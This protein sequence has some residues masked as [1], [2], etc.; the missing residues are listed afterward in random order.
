MDLNDPKESTFKDVILTEVRD[1]DA[2]STLDVPSNTRENDSLKDDTTANNCNDN[3]RNDGVNKVSVTPVSNKDVDDKKMIDTVVNEESVAASVDDEENIIVHI[4]EENTLNVGKEEGIIS[5]AANNPVSMGV[6]KKC[7]PSKQNAV[8]VDLHL[9]ANHTIYRSGNV[10]DKVTSDNE[11]DP[12]SSLSSS[13]SND[14]DEPTKPNVTEKCPDEKKIIE[15]PKVKGELGIEDLP[16]IEELK[17]TA[18]DKVQL[19]CVGLISTIID[20]LVVV[21]SLE[22]ESSPLNDD[23]IL[24]LKDRTSLGQ[25]FEIFGPVRN[26]MYSVRFNTTQDIQEKGLKVGT[27][28]YYAPKE[29]KYTNYVFVQDLMKQKGSD[30]SWEHDLEPPDKFLDYSD[31]EKERLM[32]K[33]K[34]KSRDDNSESDDSNKEG[35]NQAHRKKNS[36]NPFYLKNDSPVTQKNSK[37]YKKKSE[38]F[39]HQGHRNDQGSKPQQINNWHSNAYTSWPPKEPRPQSF[40]ASNNRFP[41]TYGNRP[42]NPPNNW[43]TNPPNQWPSNPANSWGQTGTNNWP[44]TNGPNKWPRTPNSWSQGT[45]NSWSQGTP[46]SWSQSTPNN[47]SQNTPNNWSLNAPNNWSQNNPNTSFQNTPNSS[48]QMTPNNW[49]A[50][51]SWTQ[52]NPNSWS[53]NTPNISAQNIPHG[54]SQINPNTWSSNWP[55]NWSSNPNSLPPNPFSVPPPNILNSSS[56]NSMSQPSAALPNNPPPNAPSW[57]QNSFA[58]T[59]RFLPNTNQWPP[60]QAGNVNT[61]TNNPNFNS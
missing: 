39:T 13:S 60:Q 48:T 43:S 11:S 18:D 29:L 38:G 40:E 36:N 59:Q 10:D 61:G 1:T 19:V 58:Q 46:N 32:K 23:S 21:Q 24:F 25:V 9:N 35:K 5:N 4:N 26:P 8:N 56:S 2:E 28:I 6:E 27:E 17:I 37:N 47:W 22:S 15:K 54:S 30:A 45:S 53:Q 34:K 31:D 50:L 42:P 49:P 57:T 51:N 12:S 33:N 7:E 52:N 16:P 14:D 44:S 20:T 3:P 55:T 41:N